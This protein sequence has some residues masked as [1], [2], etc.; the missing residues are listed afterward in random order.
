[1]LGGDG[2]HGGGDAVLVGQ[3]QLQRGGAKALGV[4]RVGEGPHLRQV[5]G[6]KDDVV[7]LGR[8]LPGHLVAEPALAARAGD[9]CDR[10]S[11][12]LGRCHGSIAPA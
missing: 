12:L 5:P 8:Q 2:A 10:R 11:A 3:V 9:E 7:P 1:M 4:D 6:G